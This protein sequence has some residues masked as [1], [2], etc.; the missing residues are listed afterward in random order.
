MKGMIYVWD[1]L[2]SSRLLR[3]HMKTSVY[4]MWC[5]PVKNCNGITRYEFWNKN[6]H[7]GGWRWDI[8]HLDNLNVWMGTGW[9]NVGWVIGPFENSKM[10][11]NGY[12]WVCLDKFLSILNMCC[13]A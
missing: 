2:V 13:F 1:K 4:R 7:G 6:M 8:K 3:M 9:E 5:V 11:E 10:N 12:W